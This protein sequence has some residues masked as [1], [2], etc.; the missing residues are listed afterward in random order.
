MHADEIV[1]ER[2]GREDSRRMRDRSR[3]SDA[4]RG[5]REGG[6]EIEGGK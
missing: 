5:K 1:Q 2:K 6:R 4:S 3:R